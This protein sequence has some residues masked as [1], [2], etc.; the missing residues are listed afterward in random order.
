M[1]NSDLLRNRA[2]RKDPNYSTSRAP[3]SKFP[4]PSQQEKQGHDSSCLVAVLSPLCTQ[5]D[6][7]MPLSLLPAVSWECSS[8]LG[9]GTLRS[10]SDSKV[11]SLTHLGGSPDL[12]RASTLPIQVEN[13]DKK[14]KSVHEAFPCA[15]PAL[16]GEVQ[17]QTQHYYGA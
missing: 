9:T 4:T 10:P 12:Q 1:G 3:C 13:L 7:P 8:D 16:T 6:I 15:H 14:G 17:N 2:E 5:D 11:F